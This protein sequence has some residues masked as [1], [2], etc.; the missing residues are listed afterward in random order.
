[1]TQVKLTERMVSQ[2]KA[3]HPS[4]KQVLHWDTELKGFGVLVSGK[5]NAKTYIV[6]RRLPNGR[7]RRITIEATNV[8]PL[9]QARSEAENA[10]HD[11]RVGQ[12][13]K[14]GRRAAITL[15]QVLEEYLATRKSLREKSRTGYR[16]LIETYLSDWLTLRIR[17][18]T[19]E[20]VEKKHLAI[21][22]GIEQ[23]AKERDAAKVK[24]QKSAPAV[25]PRPAET[26]IKYSGHATA[27]STM[28]ALRVLWNFASDRD[29]S[30][31]HINPV[32][33]LRKS[34]FHV[35]RRESRVPANLLPAFFHA[36]DT[37][38]NK[39]ARD[40]LMLLLFTGMR[41]GEAATLLWDDI[42]FPG[43]LIRLRASQTKSKRRANL[44]MTDFV[45][46]LLS[47][48]R[49]RG[50]EGP[51]VFPAN[52]RS[53]HIE[54]PRFA[55]QVVAKAIGIFIS[56]HDLRRTFLG[57]AES[58]E[59]SVYALKAL[60]NHASGS[61]VTAGYL[62]LTTERLRGPAQRVADRLQELCE[63]KREDRFVC[64]ELEVA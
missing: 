6:Q 38:E 18:I 26:A 15:K 4:G 20:M 25:P 54:E 62:G 14:A 32:R 28:V 59:M 60:V 61:D 23:R 50:V 57:V 8:L 39:T 41:K 49:S 27:N 34:W 31:P 37:L 16:K 1:M 29:P 21:Q 33:R 7:Q 11:I 56:P 53:G 52:T 43:G 17:D 45:T 12:D 47:E 10:L 51:F 35:G 48:R 55:L 46:A 36:V 63:A 9:E 5:T 3:P 58:T 64:R 42:D 24:L 30:L 22:A 19:P 13:P 40:F 2:L 44:P